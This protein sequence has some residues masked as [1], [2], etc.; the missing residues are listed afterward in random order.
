MK[1]KL[2]MV[3]VQDEQTDDIIE[4]ARSSGATGC[5]VVTNARGEGLEPTPTFFGLS[6]TGQRD[7]VLLLVEEHLSRS[8][9]E[10]IDRIGHFDDEHGT[11]VALQLDIEDAVG[12]R[13]QIPKIKDAIED[14]L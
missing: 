2:I 5:T 7:L 9:L 11:G 1:F 3:M 8:I 10:T 14:E 4:A 12:L 13:S 6:L